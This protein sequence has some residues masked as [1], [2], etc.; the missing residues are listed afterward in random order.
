MKDNTMPEDVPKRSVSKRKKP[1]EKKT[2]VSKPLKTADKADNDLMRLF[3]EIKKN[4]EEQHAGNF[5]AI[6]DETQF[7]GMYREM[8]HYYNESG[9]LHIRNILKILEI[10][11]AYAEGD[12]SKTLEKLPG[13]QIIAN[14]KMELL[15]NNVQGL[16]SELEKLTTAARDG[17]FNVRGE[18]SRFGGDYFF[19]TTFFLPLFSAM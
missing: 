15:K 8:V 9:H 1:A 7:K 12:F 16:I 18:V 6:I 11:S 13:K 3:K 10:L 14:E 5:E 19:S 2:A 4:Y 17:N